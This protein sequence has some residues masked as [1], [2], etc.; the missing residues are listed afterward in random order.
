M[1]CYA[2]NIAEMRHVRNKQYSTFLHCEGLA[3][4]HLHMACTLLD[5]DRA[6]VR[7]FS[8]PFL[9]NCFAPFSMGDEMIYFPDSLLDQLLLEDINQGDLTTRALGIGHKEGV[10]SFS[11][12]HQCRSSGI[13]TASSLL[14]KLGLRISAQ[15]ADGT[16]MEADQEL[17]TAEGP[18]ARL[19]QGWKVAQNVLEWSCGVAGFMARM[20]ARA[21]AVNPGVAIACT[22]KSIPGTKLLAQEA[23]LNGGGII[24]RGGTGETLLLFANHRQFWPDPADWKGQIDR[25]RAQAP[26]KKIVVEAKTPDEALG[27]LRGGTDV[28]QLDKFTPDGIRNIRTLAEQEAPDCLIIAA[29]GINLDTVEAYAATG[30]PLLVSSAP[31]YAKPADV[32][33]TLRP[34]KDHP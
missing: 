8:H 13:Q 20:L 1:V 19:H 10:M 29:G 18:A 21:R 2:N 30:V 14:Q 26:E 34:S 5:M 6:A 7:L 9:S 24:H 17:L 32:K 23:V 15:A 31:Y 22:R 12:R 33:V 3:Y 25:L 16:N 28:L 27:A 4:M 11:V